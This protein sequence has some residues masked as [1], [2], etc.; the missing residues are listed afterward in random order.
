MRISHRY[1]FVFLSNPRTA[2]RSIRAVLDE[3]SDIK[4]VHSSRVSKQS[5]FYH[6]MPAGEAKR[7][8]DER[9]WDWF[10]YRRFCI[11]RNPYARM[12]S[13]YHHYL[14]MRTRIAPDL[15]PISK[16]KALV[17]YRVMP[18]QSFSEYAVR[19]DKIRQIAMPLDE[20][21]FDGDG[22]CLVDD[23][24]RYEALAEELPPYL[25]G[26]GIDVDP[27]QIPVLGASN[28]NSY[29]G[30][31]DDETVSLVNELY[32]YAIDRFGYSIDELE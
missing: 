18:R 11:V 17:K 31:Y 24:I 29:K 25:Q 21:I 13:L 14:N 6:H 16:L 12:V 4:S 30:Y 22:T 28:I 26:I 23:I 15:A 20:F 1:R 3:Y 10:E 32:H 9:R 2:S 27:Q 7:V 8:F 5:P 19:P